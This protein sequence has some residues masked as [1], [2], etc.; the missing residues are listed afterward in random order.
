MP[1][2]NACEIT[3]S[4]LTFLTKWL[5][6]HILGTDMHMAKKI[7][8][9]QA[10]APE[11]EASRI[12]DS[13]M[14]NATEAILQAM[15][16]LYENLSNQTRYLL[17]AKRRLDQ[18]IEIRKLEE[19]ELRIAATA[20]ESH[21]GMII[22]DVHTNI[23]RVNQAF[24]TITGYSAEEVIGKTPNILSSGRQGKDFYRAMWERIRNDGS[25]EGEIWNMRKNGEIYPEHLT[26]TA[27]NNKAGIVTH[28]VGALTDITERQKALDKLH[29]TA[30]DL[31]VANLQVE[32]ERAKLAERVEE[33]TAQLKNANKAKDTFL[34]TMSHEIRTPLGGLMGTMELLDISNLGIKQRE[35]LKTARDSADSLLRIV[36][37]ILDWSKIEAGK[38]EIVAHPSSICTLLKGVCNTYEPVASVKN[39]SLQCYC[40]E[41]L[42]SAHQFDRLRISQILNNLT[43]NA[44]KFTDHGIVE[45]RAEL[46]SRNSEIETIQFSVKDSGIGISTEHQARIFQQYEQASNETARMYGGTGLGLAICHQLAEL[47]GGKLSVESS[48]GQ[49]STFIFTLDM[50]IA[51]LVDQRELQQPINEQDMRNDNLDLAPLLVQGRLITIL[52]VDDHPV[53]RMLLKKQL[54]LLGLNMEVAESGVSALSLYQNR[55]FDLVIT[56]CHMQGMDGYE[57]TRQIRTLEQQAGAERIPIIAWTANVMAEEA[58][59]CKTAGMDD[60]LTK[61]TDLADLRAMLVKWMNRK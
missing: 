50:P 2:A 30:I 53:N 33:R 12:A 8:A 37:D 13:F 55:H 22:T 26:I 39:I 11:D 14:H 19:D 15:D 57:L 5:L 3:G 20:F 29:N 46:T 41:K 23:I 44:L 4:T 58:E 45:V 16:R 36:N 47:M 40:D 51:K 38:L 31:E 52:I 43:S 34:A 42:S 1:S 7:L 27:V 17:E 24:T 21:E 10:G 60:I 18:E 61:P 32:T 35:L 25:W 9:L 59:R 56:D 54:E 28:Y 6:T 49:G 48:P